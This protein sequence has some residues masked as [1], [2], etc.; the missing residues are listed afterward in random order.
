MVI[1]LLDISVILDALNG[2]RRRRELLTQLVLDASDLAYCPVTIVEVYAGVRDPERAGTESVL[3]SLK[4]YA[5]NAEIAQIAGLNA[6]GLAQ[7]KPYC[8]R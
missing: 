8:F 4:V 5:I 6:N 3:S 7:D 1:I 2:K